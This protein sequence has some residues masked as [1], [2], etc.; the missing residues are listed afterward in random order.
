MTGSELQEPFTG[1]IRFNQVRVSGNLPQHAALAS[2]HTYTYAV[3]VHNTGL[4][5]EA[6]FADPRLDQQATIALPDQNGSQT[7]ISLPLPAGLT[8]PYYLVPTHTSQLQESLT[9]SVP[10]NFDT[11]YFPGD[12]DVEGIPAG[13]SASLTLTEPEISPGLWDL[14]PDEIGPYPASG[15]P[16]ATASASVNAVMQAF[17]PAAASSTGDAWSYYN[18]LTS[19]F[20]P[21]Y[22]PAGGS[23]T[24][25]VTITP[26]AAPGSA[27]SGTLYVAD[28]ALGSFLFG[29]PALPDADD[30]A[31]LPYSYQV[32]S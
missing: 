32:T 16:P 7:N 29:G 25:T 9:G 21:A 31:A 6:F 26:D 18:G 20:T 1:A 30:L 3:T 4:A 2:G 8:F 12:P 22:V 14:N 5:P 27:V 13:D 11:E 10:V 15:A 19:T 17:D 23:A 24:I 28:F